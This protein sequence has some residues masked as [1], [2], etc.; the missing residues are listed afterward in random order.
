MK[1]MRPWVALRWI[2]GACSAAVG[3]VVGAAAAAGAAAAVEATPGLSLIAGGL[4]GWR[5]TLNF[6]PLQSYGGMRCGQRM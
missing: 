4:G 6:D 3:T 2:P 1:R 5:N